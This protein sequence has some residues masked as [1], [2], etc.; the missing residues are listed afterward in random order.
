MNFKKKTGG[1]KPEVNITP[2]VDAVFILLIFFAVSA[3]FV[4]VGGIQV[5]LPKAATAS[6]V[7]KDVIRVSVDKDSRIEVDGAQISV[8]ELYDVLQKAKNDNPTASLVI[9]ADKGA[10]HGVVVTIIDDGKLAG[11]ERFTI[12]TEE[13]DKK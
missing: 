3:S 4:Y 12:A 1:I 7:A 9:Q 10:L 13:A 6:E 5:E 8:N 2:L 11:F